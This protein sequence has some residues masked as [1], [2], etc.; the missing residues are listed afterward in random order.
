MA[1]SV[2][3]RNIVLLPKF[4]G[5]SQKHKFQLLLFNKEFKNMG[6]HSKYTEYKMSFFWNLNGCGGVFNEL[7][8][9]LSEQEDFK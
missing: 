1:K 9:V 2:H 7:I 6:K 5:A 4:M 8:A 3:K